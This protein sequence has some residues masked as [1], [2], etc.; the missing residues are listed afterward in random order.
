MTV[1]ENRAKRAMNMKKMVR[2]FMGW[3]GTARYGWIF[4]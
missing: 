2:N 3:D 1:N 4:V